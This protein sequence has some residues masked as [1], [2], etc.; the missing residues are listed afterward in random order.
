MFDPNTN[1]ASTSTTTFNDNTDKQ[2]LLILALAF[3]PN[4]VL[5]LAASYQMLTYQSQYVVKY[6]GTTSKSDSRLIIHGILNF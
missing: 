6:D 4:K 1:N 3:K 2:S 5:T